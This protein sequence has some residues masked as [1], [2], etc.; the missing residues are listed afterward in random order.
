MRALRGQSLHLLQHTRRM[1]KGLAGSQC[2][3]GKSLRLLL[4]SPH[5]SFGE[6]RPDASGIFPLPV[7]SKGVGDFRTMF[8]NNL[9]NNARTK[10]RWMAC[11][12]AWE[13]LMVLSLNVAAGHRQTGV[14]EPSSL[15]KGVL[16]ALSADA[17]RFV[18]GQ[19]PSGSQVGSGRFCED[20]HEDVTCGMMVRRPTFDWG[21]K[22]GQLS[23]SYSGEVC[24]KAKWLTSEQVVPGLPPPGFGGSLHAV[25]F[26]SSWVRKH[27]E[28]PGLSR[29][30]DDEV[31]DPLPHAVVRATQ[32]S[33]EQIAG[34]LTKRGIACVIPPEDCLLL[35]I[36][37]SLRLV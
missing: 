16:D 11:T 28:D 4:D 29:L 8:H 6:I 22:L 14:W 7:T 5:G 21:S 34:E 10:Q 26:C 24:E 25:D 2:D 18:W 17:V 1:A 31:P 23:L 33:W 32:Q 20:G 36:P 15:Q 35:L 9:Y 19:R 3:M 12:G 37:D 30:S 27:L 13:L